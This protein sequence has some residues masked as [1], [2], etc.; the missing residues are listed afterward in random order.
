MSK[1]QELPTLGKDGYYRINVSYN[2]RRYPVRSK[3]IQGVYQKAAAKRKLLEDGVILANGNTT[4][5]QW[6][7]EWLSTYHNG[8]ITPKVYANYAQLIRDTILPEVGNFHI[9]DV[10]PVHLQRI[11]NSQA[12]MSRSHINKVSLLL[13][14]IFRSALHN[15]M[16]LQN[17]ADGLHVPKGTAGS[18]RSITP[19]ER[20]VCLR[21][22]QE[23]VAGLWIKT[24]LYT[25][26]RPGE[27]AALV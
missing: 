22:A 12:G 18:H 5:R 7:Q 19:Y 17:P 11:L 9:K 16:I 21:V 8:D 26:M 13:N 27:S 4:V 6:A 25:G 20:E 15:G 14:Q 1:K 3:T 23:H 2:G 10:K 24:M